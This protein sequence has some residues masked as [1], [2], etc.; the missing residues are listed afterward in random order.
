MPDRLRRRG[1]VALAA[2]AAALSLAVV[3]LGAPQRTLASLTDTAAIPGNGFATAATFCRPQGLAFL[4]G[5]EWG[6]ISGLGPFSAAATVGGSPMVDT[7]AR[8]G[9]YGLK[10]AKT[11]TGASSITRSLTGSVVVTRVAVMLDVLP[12]S[13]VT[14]LLSLQPTLGSAA[15]VRFNPAGAKL[16]LALGASVAAAT[17]PVVAGTWVVVD[18]TLDTSGATRT[19]G[20]RVDGVAQT[21]V[22]I[23]DVPT[24]VASL[25]L[26][27]N[28][29]SDAYVARY[30]DVAIGRSTA[31]FPLSDG[32]V[33]GLAPNAS[34]TAG[35]SG[36]TAFRYDNDSPIDSNAF[37]R[38][39]EVPMTSTAAYVKQISANAGAYV[40]MSFTDVEAGACV[41]G[42][43]AT[44]A[45]RSG[46]GGGANAA[47]TRILDG[48]TGSTVHTGS[49]V[50]T[51]LQYAS[52][53][54]T[55][56]AG[57]WTATAVN[58][59][60]A[61]IGYASD[62]SPVPYWDALRLEYDVSA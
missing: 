50:S 59:L 25:V 54:V 3:G 8:S 40:Q 23:I 20:W 37:A 41:S 1:A 10:I 31:T 32:R 34:P 62:V 11:S 7:V 4:T 29:T 16:E 30:D 46:G 15:V 2:L 53:M 55:P 5:F 14:Q 28:T 60:V 47:S 12:S 35:N 21:S 19:A 26:G 49:M 51:S 6:P 27:S 44:V 43:Q 52:A 58:G 24:S 33:L 56:A 18:L 45:Y 13:S 42:V 39:A 57:S 48:A 22:S 38:L 9:A 17:V 36:S 61:R